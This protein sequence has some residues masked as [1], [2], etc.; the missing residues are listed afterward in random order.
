MHDISASYLD[1]NKV[2]SSFAEVLK[3]SKRGKERM[4]MRDRREKRE[5]R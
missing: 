3:K 5:S 4:N 2:L 1:F